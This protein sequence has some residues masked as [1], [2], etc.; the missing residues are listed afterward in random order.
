[1]CPPRIDRFQAKIEILGSGCW[2][3]TG[4]INE[5]G[6]GNFWDLS[7]TRSAHVVSYE[8]YYDSVPEGMN[9]CHKC[10]NRWCVNPEHLFLGTTQ[11]NIDDM[12]AKGRDGF[13]GSRNGRALLKEEQIAEIRQLLGKR[14]QESIATMYG[15]SRSTISAISTGRNWS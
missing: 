11:D 12:I 6:Y 3:W 14:S 7:T 1:M 10:D 13:I 4:G 15:V 5:S 8:I 9:V 2:Q